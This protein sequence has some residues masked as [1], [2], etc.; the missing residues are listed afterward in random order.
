[1]ALA[2]AWSLVAGV[3]AALAPASAVINPGVTP[4]ELAAAMAASGL[5]VTAASFD[6]VPSGTPYGVDDEPLAGFPRDGATFAL[7]STGNAQH[8]RNPNNSGS[9]STGNGGGHVGG[10]STYDVVIFRIGLSVPPGSDCL[11]FDFKFFSEEY[12]EFVGSGFNDA[13]LVELDVSD[14]SV[15]GSAISAPHNFAFDEFGNPITINAAGA[16]TMTPEKANGTTYDGATS[17]LRAT[18][19]VAAGDHSVFFSI[20]DMGDD[21]YDS[22]VFLDRL[23]VGTSGDSGCQAGAAPPEL[24]PPGPP[25]DL[26]AAGGTG[27]VELTWSPPSSDGGS[28]I[29]GYR[30]YRDDGAGFALLAE[31]D[32][33]TSSYVNS[34]LPACTAFPY[35]VTAV[36]GEGEGPPAIATGG[37]YCQ[38]GAPG[39][40]GA[41]SGPDFGQVSLE[42]APPAYD[43]GRPT[44]YYSLHRGDS[45]DRQT[46]F[47]DVGAQE[48]AYVDRGLEDGAHFYYTLT[49]TNELGEGPPS[50]VADGASYTRQGEAE[51]GPLPAGV[52]ETGAVWQGQFAYV[53]GGVQGDGERES[54]NAIVRFDPDTGES[55]TSNLTLPTPRHDFPALWMPASSGMIQSCHPA[56]AFGGVAYLFGGDWTGGTTV[57][58]PQSCHP[59]CFAGT[60][61]LKFIP[62]QD[63]IEKIATEL[64]DGL[65]GAAGAVV[66]EDGFIQ[67]CHPACM[68]G[69]GYLF[70]GERPKLDAQVQG[71]APE[72]CHPACAA[73]FDD[74]I[75]RF[76]PRTEGLTVMSARLPTPR[77]QMSAAYGNGYVYLFG[78]MDATGDLAEMLRYDPVADVVETLNVTLPSPRQGTSAF[79]D[80]QAAYIVGGISNGTRLDDIVRF[81]PSAADARVAGELPSG[82]D[83]TSVV[84]DGTT[85]YIFGGDDGNATLDEVVS[86]TPTAPQNPDARPEP[87]DG[88]PA[89]GPAPRSQSGSGA[90]R[91]LVT[92]GAPASPGIAP[93]TAY[94]VYRA[95]APDEEG[96]YATVPASQTSFLDVGLPRATTF[97]YKIS[98]VSS[99]GEGPQSSEVFATTTD[100]PGAP[101]ELRALPGGV[102]LVSL[103]WQAPLSD[104]GEA[105]RVYRVYRSISGLGSGIAL[106]GEVN[107]AETTLSD[108]GCRLGTFCTYVL[109]AVNVHG[110]GPLSNAALAA[111]T[112]V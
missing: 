25:E 13:F 79:W 50:N 72:S 96:L 99:V 62:D 16:A 36:N 2:V 29:T 63:S 43:G 4:A 64:P 91:I 87:H 57:G 39:P 67:S 15:N 108:P 45:P 103:A 8:A 1:M 46:W 102:G 83:G 66:P 21:S 73:G 109:A 19:P 89:A 110:Q 32:A 69:L 98:A 85:A 105:L 35:R 97:Y 9:T 14:W 80:G 95:T 70:G 3:L 7:L 76:D 42:W 77:T 28:P 10:D 12:P 20:F 5:T 41:R 90:G 23:L 24:D 11:T 60:D 59:A 52:A 84:Y 75:L 93:L 106:I 53:F 81:E 22:T 100:L 51:P 33:A 101:R 26:L 92:W 40:L 37:T 61:I 58:A 74:E 68:T 30:V 82:R 65:A 47:A 49:A 17:V 86:F 48:T 56:C 18:T 78:G 107:A 88:S 54:T 6:A 112:K 111:G 94:N 71:P 104:G 44:L 27:Q 31:L 34:G 38:P 55:V